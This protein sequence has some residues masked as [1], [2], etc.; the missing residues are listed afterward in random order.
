MRIGVIGAGVIGLHTARAL[1]T[2]GHS[3]EVIAE[4]LPPET[5]SDVAGA[6]W[7]PLLS[8][9]ERS[10]PSYEERLAGWLERSWRHLHALLEQPSGVSLI[11]SHELFREPTEPPPYLSQ[12][13]PNFVSEDD[14][15]LPAGFLH[16][17]SFT[18][19]RIE[20]PIHMRWL[21]QEVGSMGGRIQTRRIELLAGE[22]LERFDVVVNCSGLGARALF[23]DQTLRGIKGQVLLHDPI[24][25]TQALGAYDFGILPRADALVLGS[26]FLGEF[27]TEEPTA[28]ETDKIWDEVTGWVRVV[29]GGVGLPPGSLDRGR[30]RSVSA[31]LRPFRPDGVRLELDSFD[32]TTVVHNYGHGAS[33]FTL[34]AG[35]AAEVVSIA[36]SVQ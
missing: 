1:L 35:C 26:L 14:P 20:T 13:L 27:S 10:S 34:A 33:G 30:I 31:G 17:W 2:E 19:L 4:A 21:L 28:Q 12:I 22:D 11:R 32:G 6:I 23:G 16:R 18:T 29:E 25:F 24:P 9:D 15:N 8:H 5:T 7:L 3:V 36:T